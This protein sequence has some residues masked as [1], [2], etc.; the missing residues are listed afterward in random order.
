[1]QSHEPDSGGTVLDVL[2]APFA[3]ARAARAALTE[4]EHAA[5]SGT[6]EDLTRLA[7]AQDYF[8]AVQGDAIEREASTIA[9]KVGFRDKDLS[10]T[11]SSLSGGERGRLQLA[12]VLASRPDLLLLDEPTNHLDLETVEWLEGFVRSFRGAVIVV[13]HDRAFLDATCDKT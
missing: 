9:H 3:Q 5:A 10:R 13:S 1:H 7:H 4:S 8:H 6:E 12:A 11:V 2:F